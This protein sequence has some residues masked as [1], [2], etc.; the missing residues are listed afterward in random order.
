MKEIK[1]RNFT[2]KHMLLLSSALVVGLG[3]TF[4]GTVEA[5]AP[6]PPIADAPETAAELEAKAA[7][8]AATSKKTGKVLPQPAAPLAGGPSLAEQL[9]TKKLKKGGVEQTT[10]AVQDEATL[11]AEADAATE[12]ETRHGVAAIGHAAAA[13]AHGKR[14]AAHKEKALA[15]GKAKDSITGLMKS[16]S[17]IPVDKAQASK[18]L[19]LGI[20]MLL[21]QTRDEA[22]KKSLSEAKN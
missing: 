8:V 7:R 11:S 16:L 12:A 15:H 13:A 22:A 19:W 10:S 9:R 18:K 1:S 17:A 14:A 20:G 2:M 4:V 21:D 5:A 3:M 6:P